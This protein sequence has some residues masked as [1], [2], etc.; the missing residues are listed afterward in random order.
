MKFVTMTEEEYRSDIKAAFNKGFKDGSNQVN[1]AYSML[2]NF[3]KEVAFK[4]E[5]NK[6]PSFKDKDHISD[7]AYRILDHYKNM[8]FIKNTMKDLADEAQGNGQVSSEEIDG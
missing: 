4:D 6:A 2:I 1:E 8:E 7:M 5:S 3:V